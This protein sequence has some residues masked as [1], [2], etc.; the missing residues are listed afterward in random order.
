MGE[1][2][3]RKRMKLDEAAAAHGK[4]AAPAWPPT[5]PAAPARAHIRR[6]PSKRAGMADIIGKY[7]LDVS[8]REVGGGLRTK[9]I[10]SNLR[11]LQEYDE[12]IHG[13]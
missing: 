10:A 6:V 5:K 1:E 3:P 7:H 4:H 9:S 11:V 2:M 13:P 12:E 8:G